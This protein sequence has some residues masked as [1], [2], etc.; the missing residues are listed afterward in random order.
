MGMTGNLATYLASTED[1]WV[2]DFT[3]ITFAASLLYNYAT[4]VCSGLGLGLLDSAV[5]Y[6]AWNVRR[7]FGKQ[8]TCPYCCGST[9][10]NSN[11]VE[12]KNR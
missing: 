4:L 7:S 9:F 3:K 5:L 6:I 8:M 11:M 1:E 2:Y 12:T 10:F